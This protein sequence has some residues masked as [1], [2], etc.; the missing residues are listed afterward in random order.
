M[1]KQKN[2]VES[3]WSMAHGMRQFNSSLSLSLNMNGNEELTAGAAWIAGKPIFPIE[4]L[5]FRP[6]IANRKK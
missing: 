5:S 2:K 3:T 1:M 6:N 4:S